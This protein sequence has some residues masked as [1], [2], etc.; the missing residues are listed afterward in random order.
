[1]QSGWTFPSIAD[2]LFPPPLLGVDWFGESG[3]RERIETLALERS[4]EEATATIYGFRVS[5]CRNSITD[6]EILIRVG[7]L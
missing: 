2:P 5:E 4:T 1:M 7:M 3:E 6:F